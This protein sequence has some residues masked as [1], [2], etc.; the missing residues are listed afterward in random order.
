AEVEEV[1]SLSERGETRLIDVR[2]PEE[3]RA[4]HVPGAVNIPLAELDQAGDRLPADHEAPVITVCNRGN[5][6]L[7]GLLVLKSLGYRNV[8]S[9]N[10]GTTAWVEQ[11]NPVESE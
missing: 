6:S 1:R 5:M 3:Y 9:L 7:N 10:G 8:R 11:G 4:G 2:G